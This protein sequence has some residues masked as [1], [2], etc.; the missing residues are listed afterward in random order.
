MNA[1]SGMKSYDPHVQLLQFTPNNMETCLGDM[2]SYIFGFMM[3]QMTASQGIRKHGQKAIDT[4]FSEFCQLNNKEVFDPMDASLLTKDQKKA[5]LHAI[6]LIKEKHNGVLKGSMCADGS[7][8]CTLYTKED[9]ASPM[10]ATDALMLSLM[11]D[12]FEK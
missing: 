7:V 4:L 9:T 5:A 10:V 12:A 3:N 1:S 8:Q 6:N 11:I 2:F